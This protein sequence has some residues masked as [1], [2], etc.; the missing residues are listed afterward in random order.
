[1]ESSDLW[2]GRRRDGHGTRSVLRRYRSNK[3]FQ[4]PKES[5]KGSHI[6]DFI[7]NFYFDRNKQ[8]IKKVFSEVYVDK[9]N[10][11]WTH[12]LPRP[13]LFTLPGIFPRRN[14][15]DQR[16][17]QSSSE[18]NGRVYVQIGPG[19]RPHTVTDVV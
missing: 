8:S 3:F 11:V 10:L 13:F 18:H 4:S 6:V 16:N 19:G 5:K 14:C 15:K 1:M 12:Q 2:K 17:L 9:K 7:F